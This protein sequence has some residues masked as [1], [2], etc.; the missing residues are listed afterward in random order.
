MNIFFLLCILHFIPIEQY[1]NRAVIEWNNTKQ[2][3]LCIYYLLIKRKKLLELPDI[4]HISMLH[5][6]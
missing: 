3:M 1:E 4:N 6:L 5:T 2:K